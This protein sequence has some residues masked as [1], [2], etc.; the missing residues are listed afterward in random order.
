MYYSKKSG[1]TRSK[2]GP[3]REVVVS[4]N[5]KRRLKTVRLLFANDKRQDMYANMFQMVAGDPPALVVSSHDH[6]YHPL[7]N[8]LEVLETGTAIQQITGFQHLMHH[9]K[10][11][12]KERHPQEH[13][14]AEGASRKS[15]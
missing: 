14:Y 10:E 5:H 7:R 6:N 13:M 1:W 2:T 15:R 11:A 9:L 3:V 8:L 4:L 12:C